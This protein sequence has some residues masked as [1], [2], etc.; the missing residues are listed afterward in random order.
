MAGGE[1]GGG[2]AHCTAGDFLVS[3]EEAPL[4]GSNPYFNILLFI[5]KVPRYYT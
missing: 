4:R 5:E 2:R 3:S 1:G